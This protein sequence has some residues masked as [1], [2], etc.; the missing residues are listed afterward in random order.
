M[1]F[2]YIFSQTGHVAFWH[3]FYFISVTLGRTWLLQHTNNIFRLNEKDFL[4]ILII[5]SLSHI[6]KLLRILLLL[7]FAIKEKSKL[8]IYQSTC[9][10]CSILVP[11][12]HE[13]HGLLIKFDHYMI[14]YDKMTIFDHDMKLK[15][16]V[17]IFHSKE[18]AHRY[19]ICKF[20]KV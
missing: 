19:M 5:T 17:Q 14:K 8:K 16:H 1:L 2:W 6:T 9:A 10:G 3:N 11:H 7:V 15:A 20:L 18:S 4:Q 12:W 13:M